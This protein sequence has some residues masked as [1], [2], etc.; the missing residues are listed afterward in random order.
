MSRRRHGNVI[1][2]AVAAPFVAALVGLVVASCGND[3]DDNAV[4]RG[5]ASSDATIEGSFDAFLG[6]GT[7]ESTPGFDA[8]RPDGG[9]APVVACGDGGADAGTGDAGECTLPPSVCIDDHWLRYYAGGSCN[10]DA[11]T[12]DFRAFEMLCGPSQ[13][14]PDCYQGGCRLV[15]VR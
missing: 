13:T 5:D 14:P 9:P 11:G 12:C 7:L 3:G 15:I 2:A 10:T 1:T 4:K 6:D 8:A